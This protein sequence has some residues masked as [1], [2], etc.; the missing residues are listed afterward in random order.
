MAG[1]SAIAQGR[2]QGAGA[3]E[4]GPDPRRIPTYGPV[5]SAHYLRLP[6]ATLR[7]WVVGRSY[8]VRGGTRYF[9]PLVEVKGSKPPLLSFLNLVEAHVLAA[10]RRSHEIPLDKVRRALD[11]VERH[12]CTP[13]PLANAGFETDGLDLFIEHYGRLVNASSDGQI[14]MR[15]M[16]ETHLRRVERDATGLATRLY[17][18]TRRVEPDE[19]RVVVVDPLLGFGRPV[20]VGT[21][22]PTA[23]LADRYR[24][25][26]SMDELADDYGCDRNLVE[27]AVRCEL[28]W[29]A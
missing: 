3:A 18:F 1:K 17:L 21:G 10:I 19:P 2:A 29:A 20:L 14:A 4:R 9:K 23:V 7:S 16:L 28:R 12:C 11:F 15:Q 24:A 13:N 5:E 25:G 8:P 6:A 27:E 22:I 26:E